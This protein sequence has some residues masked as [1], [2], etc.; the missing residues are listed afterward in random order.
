[1]ACTAGSATATAY[2]PTPL[3]VISERCRE[4]QPA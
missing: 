1:L 2:M 3:I 4:A